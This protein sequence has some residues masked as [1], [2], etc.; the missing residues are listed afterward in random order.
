MCMGAGPSLYRRV[1]GGTDHGAIARTP[2][3]ME[4]AIALGTAVEP[5]LRLHWEDGARLRWEDGSR[6]R[7]IGNQREQP[8]MDG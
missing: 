5:P 6:L 7:L 3:K 4:R 2:R 1:V 8:M